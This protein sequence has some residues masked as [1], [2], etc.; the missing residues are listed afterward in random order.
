MI[1]DK[2][3]GPT[4]NIAAWH[5]DAIFVTEDADDVFVLTVWLPVTVITLYIHRMFCIQN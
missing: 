2:Y 1:N 4:S 5:Q 3:Q